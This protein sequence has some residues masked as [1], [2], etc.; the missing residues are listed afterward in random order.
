MSLMKIAI[1]ADSHGLVNRL[2]ESFQH[3]QTAGI[4]HVL[5]AGDFLEDGSV[6]VFAK[7][8]QLQ[9]FIALGNNDVNQERIEA[10]SSLENVILDEVVTLKIKNYT[11][12][13]SHYDGIAQKKSREK[14]QRVD[15]YI[16][17][18]THRAAL[19]RRKDST[20]INPGALCDDGRYLV[21]DVETMKAKRLFFSQSIP[22]K[23]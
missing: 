22:A 23:F 16:H 11:F 19:V 1:M 15:V 17:G 12:C 18:H 8:P 3:I 4:T 13:L 21:L 2:A 20:M 6:E 7:F 14:K 10:L 5:H 9:F